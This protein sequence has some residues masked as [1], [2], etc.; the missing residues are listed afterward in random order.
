M[1]T[2]VK[3]YLG[4]VNTLEVHDTDNETVNCQLDEVLSEH[5]TWYDTLSAAKA[6][7]D[8]DNCAWCIGRSTR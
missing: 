2:K 7:R 6:D 4:N 8:F 5:R 3:R 1:I